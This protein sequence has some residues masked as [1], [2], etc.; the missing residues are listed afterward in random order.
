VTK[1][2]VLGGERIPPKVALA[3]AVGWTVIGPGWFFV[4]V[5]TDLAEWKRWIQFGTGTLYLAFAVYYWALY[6]H[7][8]RLKRRE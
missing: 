1:P 2:W 6:A 7:V 4:A 5:G 8:R 3:I